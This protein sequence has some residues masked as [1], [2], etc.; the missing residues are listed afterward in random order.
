[1]P[2]ETSDLLIPLAYLIYTSRK[3]LEKRLSLCNAGSVP[4]V[5]Y[6]NSWNAFTVSKG[7]K[8]KTRRHKINHNRA[9][10]HA[11]RHGSHLYHPQDYASDPVP[12][13]RRMVASHQTSACHQTPRG[14]DQRSVPFLSR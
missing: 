4:F 14:L 7:K 10:D 13:N 5:D 1:M 2:Y 11:Q 6:L 9:R 12:Q 3:T 8:A